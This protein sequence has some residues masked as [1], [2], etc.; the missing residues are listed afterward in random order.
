MHLRGR[1]RAEA[2]NLVSVLNF[3]QQ[4]CPI[5]VPH[6]SVLSEVCDH[7]EQ[8]GVKT[9]PF[10]KLENKVSTHFAHMLVPIQITLGYLDQSCILIIIIKRNLLL[11]KLL[12][13][14]LLTTENHPVV[15]DPKR[16]LS[17]KLLSLVI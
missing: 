13:L 14:L 15:G 5:A 4:R 2:S 3:D 10:I 12:L 9:H 8:H 1:G 11:L 7:W 16:F 17:F 6:A